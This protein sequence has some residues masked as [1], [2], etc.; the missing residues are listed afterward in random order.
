[1][2]RLSSSF[3]FTFAFLSFWLGRLGLF[4]FESLVDTYAM[5]NG[6]T[7]FILNHNT[8]HYFHQLYWIFRN[9]LASIKR[10]LNIVI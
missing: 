2:Y 6:T 8:L 9:S 4:R 3:G 5:I 7:H 1:M 10:N